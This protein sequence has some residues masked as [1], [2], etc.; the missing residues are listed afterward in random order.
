M[1]RRRSRLCTIPRGKF[2]GLIPKMLMCVVPLIDMEAAKAPI[3]CGPHEKKGICIHCQHPIG[4]HHLER[5]KCSCKDCT[6]P[7]YE[8]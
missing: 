1:Q 8:G 7:G 2:E 4:Y 6:C 5:D 3:I